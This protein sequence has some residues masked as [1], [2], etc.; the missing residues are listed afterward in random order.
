MPFWSGDRLVEELPS[1]IEPFNVDHVDCAAYTMTMGSEIYITPHEGEFDPQTTTKRQLK[2]K[3]AF[4]IPA[5]QFAFLLT[6][7]ILSLPPHVLGFIS[8]KAGT[9][10]RGLIN[11]S[12]FHVDPGYDQRLVFS[13]YNA[14]PSPVHL[15]Q[16]DPLFLLWI[17][18][19]DQ[20]SSENYTRTAGHGFT[21]IPTK[22]INNIPGE[23][24]SLQSLDKKISDLDQRLFNR[25]HEIDLHVAGVR[26]EFRIYATILVILVAFLLR[27]PIF[28]EIRSL[29]VTE[30][31]SKPVASEPAATESQAPTM[32]SRSAASEPTTTDSKTPTSQ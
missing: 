9:K 32:Q 26:R 27:G 3:E 2:P 5:G 22:L 28:Q 19:L 8:M 16:G 31:L 24:H 12:G 4:A 14:G 15:Q 11:V 20:E 7:E 1:I 29:Y 13:V 17:A 23:I 10:F 30:S 21:D 25:V 18:E 6:E